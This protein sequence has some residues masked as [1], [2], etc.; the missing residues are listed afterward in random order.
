M[1]TLSRA[2]PFIVAFALLI[3]VRLFVPPS[4]L[5]HAYRYSFPASTALF[6]LLILVV[7]ALTIRLVYVMVR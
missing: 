3:L 1:T 5:L 7:I 2:A 6:Y 4:L